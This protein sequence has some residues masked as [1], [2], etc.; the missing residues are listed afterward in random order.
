MGI[1]ELENNFH[2]GKHILLDI[3]VKNEEDALNDKKM[4]KLIAS[5]A[6]EAGSNVINQVRYRFGH[7]SPPGFT[8]VV[9]LDESHVSCHAYADT[10][11][12]AI[13]VFTCGNTEPQDVVNIILE[14]L[15]VESI[16]QK[17]I[18]R[19]QI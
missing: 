18:N 13:D 8:C 2:K 12:L 6:E 14:N 17:T 3:I 5:A 9:V 7:N 4:L 15:E 19:F 10:K 16:N 1:Y 11:Q